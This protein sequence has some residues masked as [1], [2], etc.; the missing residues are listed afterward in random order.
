MPNILHLEFLR[1]YVW[2]QTSYIWN[3]SEFRYDAKHLTFGIPQN[4]C[5]M[6]SILHLEFPRVYVWCQTSYIWNSSESMSDAKQ[7]TFEI[8]RIY[9]WCQ[10]SYIWNSSE[11]RYSIA[12]DKNE[13]YKWDKTGNPFV[14]YLDG[15]I[16]CKDFQQNACK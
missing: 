3:S 10:T 15:V 5:L 8:L 7:L 4:L 6:P 12:E 1:V 9:V 2:C 14:T 16:F 13:P 11:F